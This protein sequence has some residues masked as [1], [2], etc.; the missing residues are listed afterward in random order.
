MLSRLTK[1]RTFELSTERDEMKNHYITSQ[2]MLSI[3]TGLICTTIGHWLELLN[4]NMNSWPSWIWLITISLGVLLIIMY[5][6]IHLYILRQ[7]NVSNLRDDIIN[8][9][10]VD[11]IESMGIIDRYIAPALYDKPDHIKISIRKE[12]MDRFSNTTGAVVGEFQYNRQLLHQ[13]I[14]SNAARLLIANVGEL[15]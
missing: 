1:T 2:I 15:T 5:F 11:W 12:I 14:E 9:T 4:M 7:K 10:T 6:L 3:G 13:W 8:K